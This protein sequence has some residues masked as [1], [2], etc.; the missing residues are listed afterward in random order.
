MKYRST[1]VLLVVPIVAGCA[2]GVIPLSTQGTIERSYTLEKARTAQPGEPLIV[3]RRMTSAPQYEVAFD[4][5]P[6]QHDMFQGGL[7]YL[8]LRKGM[9]FVQSATRADGAI[10]LERTGY[11]V[12]RSESVTNRDTYLPVTIWISKDGRVSSTMEGRKW[13]RDMLFL[14][15]S[16]SPG[17]VE[18]MRVEVLLDSVGGA[19]LDATYREYEGG[20]ATP[21]IDRP[22]RFNI[23]DDRRID[24]AGVAIVVEEATPASVRY[25]VVLEMFE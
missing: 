16:G 11:G 5:V 13:T 17:L 18:T 20:S 21:S 25:R 3:I 19:M 12:T 22:L 9:R 8:P 6:P 1:L 2:P 15:T 23:G 24:V 7:D 14:P 10:G 4:Y